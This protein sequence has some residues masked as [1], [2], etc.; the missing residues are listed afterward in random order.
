MSL[1]P[2][3]LHIRHVR[4]HEDECIDHLISSRLRGLMQ[5]LRFH[6]AFVQVE[7]V[8][9]AA[10]R[11]RVAIAL[12]QHGPDRQGTAEGPSPLAAFTRA[13]MAVETPRLRADVGLGVR[14]ALRRTALLTPSSSYP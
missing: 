8:G 13:L 12:S 6:R 4:L 2:L 14:S 9:L 3:S 7:R 1:P 11:Y 5:R 10:G